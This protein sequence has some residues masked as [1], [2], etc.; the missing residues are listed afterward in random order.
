MIGIA[1][2]VISGG[3]AVAKTVGAQKMANHGSKATAFFL[4]KRKKLVQQQET[5]KD[6]SKEKK[7]ELKYEKNMMFLQNDLVR[8]EGKMRRRSQ[9]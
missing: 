9:Q 6:V 7:R 3:I 5:S 2:S 1:G 8:R 4:E